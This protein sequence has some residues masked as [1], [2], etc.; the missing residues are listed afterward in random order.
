MTSV[1]VKLD[2]AGPRPMPHRPDASWHA[3][4]NAVVLAWLA[5]TVVAAVARGHLPAARWLII[6][7]F[8][9]GAV[10]N[11][12][13]TW[14]RHFATALLRL[15]APARWRLGAR[16]AALNAGVVAVLYGVS[17]GH[18]IV[19]AVG[20]AAV[21]GAVAWHVGA[22][23]GGARRALGGRFAH[24]VAWYACAGAA[25]VIGGTLGGVMAAA[26]VQAAWHARLEAAHIQANLFGWVGLTVL[27][28]LFT[29]WPTVLRTRMADDA[30]TVAR[31][32]LRLAVPGLAIAVAGLLAGSRLVAVAG[33]L[34]YAAAAALAL[35]PFATTA[36]RRRPH[37]AAAWMLAAGTGWFVVAIAADLAVVVSRPPGRVVH[38]IGPLVPLV[39]AGFVGQVLVGAL[40]FLLPVVLG[41]G[42][43]AL[44]RN[45]G[46]LERGWIPRLAVMNVAVP[47]VVV[48]GPSWLHLAAWTGLFAA[49]AAFVPL[50]GLAVARSRNRRPSPALA[51]VLAGCL[52]TAL[53]VTVAV[54]GHQGPSTS[55]VAGSGAR[56]VA[57]TLSGMRIRPGTIDAAPGVR[58]VLQVTNRDAQR[59]DLHLATGQTTPMLDPGQSATLRL[60]PLTGPIEGWCTVPGHR[61]A[62]MVMHIRV[63]GH[64]AG[65]D[66][67][68][69]MAG[70][71]GRNGPAA[72]GTAS[73]PLDLSAP[74]SPGW[75]PYDA[76]LRPAPGGTEHKVEIHAVEK[77]I[78]VAPGVWQRMWTF[79][80]TVPGP[81]LRGHVGDLFTVTFVNDTT[82]GHG[83]DFHAGAVAPDGPMR[84]IQPGQRLTYRFRAD[85][86]GAWL[87]HCS[88]MPMLQHIANGMYGAVIIDPPHLAHADREYV[89]VQGELYL[90]TPGGTAQVAKMEEGRPDAWMFNGTAA[91]YDHAPLTAHVGERVRIWVVAAGP[92]TGTA[93]HI[94]GAPFDTVYKEGAYL[95]RPGGQGGSQVLDLA[96]AQGGF[97]ETVFPEPGHYPFLDH[98]MLH[99][100]SGAHGIITVTK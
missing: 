80:G 43:A 53:A 35:V 67:G 98:D 16:L 99:G 85:R 14:S 97:V 44:K 5:L 29:L 61:A 54:S 28:T 70:M 22:L 51:G 88:A 75:R 30:G 76:T 72:T 93:F 40:T 33:L 39:L 74:M 6:H 2:P 10:T 66:M 65:G 55:T 89:L 77:V 13:V 59:H 87:Y 49:F 3:R 41:G 36:R 68:S 82:M 12:I 45:A 38:G 1:D 26:R 78:E 4:A 71:N 52:L 95:L 18:R 46:L 32:S 17:G 7:L 91:G 21:I 81:V 24:V 8:L 27:G 19:A 47:L 48:P 37:D 58:L 69:G 94:V 11:A 73:A 62:G 63:S 90:G 15:P 79:N 25:L 42:P 96:P 86:A 20:A 34:L 9:L 60:P 64:G 56:T 50:A 92:E 100:G 84:V 83:L 57:V 23:A 31:R